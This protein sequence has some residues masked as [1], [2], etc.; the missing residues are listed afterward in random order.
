MEKAL[1]I[2]TAADIGKIHIFGFFEFISSAWSLYKTLLAGHRALGL[3]KGSGPVIGKFNIKLG[4]GI[5]I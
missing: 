3:A 2:S 1:Q 4:F 5:L